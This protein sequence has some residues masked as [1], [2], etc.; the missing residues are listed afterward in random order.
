MNFFKEAHSETKNVPLKILTLP[1]LENYNRLNAA[2][3]DSNSIII[4][5]AK[6]YEQMDPSLKPAEKPDWLKTMYEFYRYDLSN[7][8]LEK[9]TE[10]PMGD[11]P[12]FLYVKK[13]NNSAFAFKTGKELVIYSFSE[14][15]VIYRYRYP[16]E[17]FG[18]HLIE[19]SPDGEKIASLWHEP[20]IRADIIYT[21]INGQKKENETIYIDGVESINYPNW[22]SDSRHIL[23]Y[24]SAKRDVINGVTVIDTLKKSYKTNK[25]RRPYTYDTRAFWG[26]E[27]LCYIKCDIVDGGGYHLNR[28]EKY[29]AETGFVEILPLPE[30]IKTRRTDYRLASSAEPVVFLSCLD[31]TDLTINMKPISSFI[32]YNY[33]SGRECHSEA[34]VGYG[35]ECIPALSPDG[36]K[37]T[38]ILVKADDNSTTLK[39]A[40]FDFSRI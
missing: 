18:L 34:I 20:K 38:I 6:Y 31:W 15:K 36:S 37:A 7:D 25:Y 30:N 2:W 13:I 26:S 22:S 5:A 23:I 39:I 21:G 24:S 33:K 19:I 32:A 40:V 8:K 11:E 10:Y 29:N 35:T 28:F 16:I 4:M 9:I 27:N 12:F 17:D 14:K 1:S 3:L